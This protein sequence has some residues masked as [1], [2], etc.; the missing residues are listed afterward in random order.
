MNSV[1]TG[2]SW[3][4][5]PGCRKR[6]QIEFAGLVIAEFSIVVS[7][8]FMGF[9]GLHKELFLDNNATVLTII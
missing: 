9:F 6:G 4:H 1:I 7:D 2:N 5:F 8:L 3:A